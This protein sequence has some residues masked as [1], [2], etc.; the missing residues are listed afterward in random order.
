MLNRHVVSA[1]TAKW[2]PEVLARLGILGT[3]IQGGDG[4]LRTKLNGL[5]YL[6]VGLLTALPLST[7]GP[8][9]SVGV[10]GG[11]AVGHTTVTTTLD[12][13]KM[14]GGFSA[15]FGFYF[16][17]QS[18]VGPQ[19]PFFPASFVDLGVEYRHFDLGKSTLPLGSVIEQ[20][21]SI[22]TFNAS[23]ALSRLMRF[24]AGP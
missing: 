13:T 3:D 23:V 5:G 6:D 4:G 9:V 18:G 11:P 17:P 22:I 15:G 19:Y 20:R 7:G 14:Q 1:F 12:Q 2:E 21:G 8:A 10:F 16:H 24:N